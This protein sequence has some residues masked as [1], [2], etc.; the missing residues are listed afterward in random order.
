MPYNA[1]AKAGAIVVANFL[2]SPEAQARKQTQMFGVING[3]NMAAQ[4]RRS[5]RLMRLTLV[6]QRQP[7]GNPLDEPHP[8]WVEAIEAEWAKRYATAQ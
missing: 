8:S 2:M 4:C 3:L 6:L 1:N 5:R 7:A